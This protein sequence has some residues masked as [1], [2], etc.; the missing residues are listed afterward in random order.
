MTPANS[1]E[2]TDGRMTAHVN[3]VTGEV[4]FSNV[5]DDLPERVA[6]LLSRIL[7]NQFDAKITVAAISKNALKERGTR[8]ERRIIT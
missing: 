7:S 2:S 4:T 8:R 6:A 5:P 3:Y 1:K